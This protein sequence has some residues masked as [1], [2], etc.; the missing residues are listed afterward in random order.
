VSQYRFM[1]A[2]LARGAQEL[3]ALCPGYLEELQVN[4]E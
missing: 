3:E 1:H 4:K 2:L